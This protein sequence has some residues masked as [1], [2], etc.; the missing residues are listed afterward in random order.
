MET[1][2]YNA[3]GSKQNETSRGYIR[4]EE[5]VKQIDGVDF[6]WITDGQGWKPSRNELATAYDN[7]SHI[8][9]LTDLENGILEK[10]IK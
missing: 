1:N 5:Q 10:I 2:Y 3:S 9:T 8:Y 4:L 7:I 6:I